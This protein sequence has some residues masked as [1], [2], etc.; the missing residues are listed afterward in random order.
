MLFLVPLSSRSSGRSIANGGSSKGPLAAASGGAAAR[1]NALEQI[2]AQDE[3][4]LEVMD[5][6]DVDRDALVVDHREVAVGGGLAEPD[7]EQFRGFRI[8][9]PDGESL[10]GVGDG[11]VV[12]LDE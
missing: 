2:V 12:H 9:D 3:A 6:G 1:R 8:G 7:L 4:A 11:H 10:I 5:V